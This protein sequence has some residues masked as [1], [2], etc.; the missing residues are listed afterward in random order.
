MN[1]T[2]KIL[3]RAVA[4]L[5][6]LVLI[7]ISV[8]SSVF[9]RYVIAKDTSTTIKLNKF[10]VS[11]GLDL[12]DEFVEFLGG[13]EVVANMMTVNG[14]SISINIPNLKM[15]PGDSWDKAFTVSIDGTPTVDCR[16]KFDV[17]LNL[18]ADKFTIPAGECGLTA[19]KKYFPID[20]IIN[21]PYD[22]GIYYSGVS[23]S[24]QYDRE[25]GLFYSL[26]ED[27]FYLKAMDHDNK[28]G[29]YAYIPFLKDEDLLFYNQND[30]VKSEL[31]TF[32]SFDLGFQWLFETDALANQADTYIV[33]HNKETGI[34]FTYVLTISLEQVG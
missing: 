17:D 3:M 7:S 11:L 1:K 21:T 18:D 32:K 4:I 5:L 23:L 25:R 6:C 12:S 30:F 10:G 31:E 9:A 14:D 33:D 22:Y 19:D 28:G 8:V 34:G 15:A 24:S 2:N 26:C 13:E 16:F 20:F 29:L 27:F